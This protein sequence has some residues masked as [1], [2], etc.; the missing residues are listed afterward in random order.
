LLVNNS[1]CSLTNN[2]AVNIIV[3]IDGI[4]IELIN[5]QTMRLSANQSVFI[6]NDGQSDDYI[7]SIDK[8]IL[9]DEQKPIAGFASN[10]LYQYN[11]TGAILKQT[12]LNISTLVMLNQTQLINLDV[13]NNIPIANNNQFVPVRNEKDLE[14]V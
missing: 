1:F 5:G 14:L 12:N 3:A 10:I 9:T 6:E 13:N 8:V 7:L 11:G 2:T 4:P